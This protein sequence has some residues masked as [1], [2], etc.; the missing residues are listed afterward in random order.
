MRDQ[1]DRSVESLYRKLAGFEERLSNLKRKIEAAE[2]SRGG[3]GREIAAAETALKRIDDDAQAAKV[4]MQLQAEERAL[5]ASGQVGEWKRDRE[6]EK[7]RS[8]AED[9]EAFAAW[10]LIV[11]TRAIDEAELATLQAIAARM[12]FENGSKE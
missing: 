3:I 7:R 4:R 8:R 2:T 10:S 1:I 11:A 9:A 5:A 12:D 6:S